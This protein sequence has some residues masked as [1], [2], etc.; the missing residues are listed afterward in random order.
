[1]V[2]TPILTMTISM[3]KTTIINNQGILKTETIGIKIITT[4][5]IIQITTTITII[6]TIQMV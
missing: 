6:E 3:L 5:I 4:T 2:I 1:M